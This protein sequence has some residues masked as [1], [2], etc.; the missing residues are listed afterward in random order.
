[1]LRNW[2]IR[3]II[4]ALF[5]RTCVG[6]LTPQ[7]AASASAA[8]SAGLLEAPWACW[9][10]DSQRHGLRTQWYR[11]K[12]QTASAWGGRR[13]SRHGGRGDLLKAA[14]RWAAVQRGRDGNARWSDPL[15]PRP[16]QPPGPEGSRPVSG[17]CTDWWPWSPP[18]GTSAR[19]GSGRST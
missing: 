2:I 17:T 11:P 7:Q 15:S 8:P 9:W 14:P 16:A 12:R 19:R 13:K 3:R 5:S 18:R 4:S 10:L 6:W 1:M